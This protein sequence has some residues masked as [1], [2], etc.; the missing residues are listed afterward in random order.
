MLKRRINQIVLLLLTTASLLFTSSPSYAARL[1]VVLVTGFSANSGSNDNS[2]GLELLNQKLQDEF[3]NN[4]DKPFSS[5]VFD[6]DQ[7]SKAFN[8]IKTFDDVWNLVLIGHSFGGD[9]IIDNLATD[10]L[11]PNN[12]MVDLTVQIDSVEIL[13][14][15]NKIP[16]NVKM[17]INYYQKG[18]IEGED[19]VKGAMNNNV[20]KLFNDPGINHTSIDDDPRLQALIIEDIK[21]K[22]MQD[23]CPIHNGNRLLSF[24][25]YAPFSHETKMKIFT[26]TTGMAEAIV[27]NRRT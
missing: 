13:G 12:I 17:G 4:P 20:E 8:Y 25:S 3:G 23:E 10:R 16:S 2:S 18:G 6:W 19:K 1:V 15:D 27:F 22:T 9:T 5:Q 26:K 21:A 24:R 14:G 7:A 11:L